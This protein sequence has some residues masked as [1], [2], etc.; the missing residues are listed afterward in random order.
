[1]TCNIISIGACSVCMHELAWS[2]IEYMQQTVISR[3]FL[4]KKYWPQQQCIG[5][6]T[7]SPGWKFD[8][9]TERCKI[10]VYCLQKREYILFKKVMYT[11]PQSLSATS[12]LTLCWMILC[13]LLTFF[14]I[15]FLKNS[16]R[17]T[18]IGSRSGLTTF[19]S[20]SGSKLFSK[21]NSRK[22]KL[23][24]ERKKLNRAPDKRG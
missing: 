5:S 10:V 24:L 2:A 20:W 1:M 9:C 22:Q 11:Q 8:C 6:S 7:A 15:T 16:F 3:H 19:W 4:G 21:V 23:P 18:I 17:S 12:Y 13:R 14:K